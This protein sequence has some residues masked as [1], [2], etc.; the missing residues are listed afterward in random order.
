MAATSVPSP[1]DVTPRRRFTLADVVAGVSVALVLI[2]QSLAYA[3]I[4]GVPSYVGLYAAALPPIVAAFV[5]SSPYLQTGPVAMT[6]L[7]TFGA[8]A[9]LAPVGS[10]EY[11][12]LAALLALLVGLVRLALGFVKAGFVAYLMSQPVVKGFTA[13]AAIL[14]AASQLPQVLGVDATGADILSRAWQTLTTPDAWLGAAAALA[15]VTAIL[16]A[17]GRRLHPLFPGVLVAVLVGI[18]YAE[19]AGY[20]GPVVGDVPGGFPPISLAL[21]W[22]SL[23]DLMLPA[24][25]IGLVGFAEPAAIARTYATQDR[26][27]WEPDREFLSQ[28]LA[29]VA[30]GLSG[31]FPVGGSFARSAIN[32]MA[33]GRTRWSGAVSGLI[34]VAFLP[35]AGVLQSL[36][37]A[38]LGAIV[39]VGVVNL[40][41]VGGLIRIWRYSRL[42]GLVAGATFVL[43]LVLSPRVD[44]A[45]L[46]GIGFGIVVHLWRELEFEVQEIV[47]G[48]ALI[49]RPHGVLYF[50][51]AP[52]VGDRMTSLLAEHPAVERINFD[53][54]HLGRIDYSGA[55]VLKSIVDDARGAD[56]TVTLQ[57][58]PPQARRIL[59]K[60]W[61][62]GLRELE[63]PLS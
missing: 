40:I 42:Q 31:G 52:A 55:L 44:V 20:S 37:S 17:G 15:L 29:N 30:S 8:L 7:L 5:A 21:P 41:D 35:I 32:R 57:R 2:P 24:I 56:L 62:G 39:I 11:V 18:A 23:R 46:I 9:N 12:G 50:G 60:V 49:V 26:Q 28:G 61:E 59:E 54:A 27:R 4:A 38:V 1:D 63:S 48:D 51:S 13:A 47:E 16:V 14:I 3:E 45:V 33:G 34:V 58:I 43:T 22:G 10:P 25:V 53:L 6:A 36:P 19:I